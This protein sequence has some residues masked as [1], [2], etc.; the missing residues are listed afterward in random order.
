MMSC[1][2]EKNYFNFVTNFKH[3][4]NKLSCF[5][6]QITLDFIALLHTVYCRQLS[7]GNNKITLFKFLAYCKNTNMFQEKITLF[8]PNY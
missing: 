2:K 7:C 5:E 6:I 3:A 1:F 4:V 8:L